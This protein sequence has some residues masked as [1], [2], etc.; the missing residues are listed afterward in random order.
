MVVL[1]NPTVAWS[2]ISVPHTND[3]KEDTRC[4]KIDRQDF[5]GPLFIVLCVRLVNIGMIDVLGEL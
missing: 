4:I 3:K 1:K 2:V 5:S